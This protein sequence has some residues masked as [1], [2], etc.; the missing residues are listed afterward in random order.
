[1]NAKKDSII[2]SNDASTIMVLS[3]VLATKGTDLCLLIPVA[4]NESSVSRS[5]F[6]VKACA[7]AEFVNVEKALQDDSVKEMWMNVV[8][9]Y[10]TVSRSA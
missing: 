6:R 2:V 7:T 5:V 1:M 10:T 4:A 3:N 8:R 9:G